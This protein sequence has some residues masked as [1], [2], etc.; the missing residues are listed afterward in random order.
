M[1][2]WVLLILPTQTEYCAVYKIGLGCSTKELMYVIK[3]Y[4]QVLDWLLENG[5][6]LMVD[7]LGGSPLHDA[8]EHGRLHA[9]TLFPVCCYC[10]D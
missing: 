2:G 9:S 4:L 8:A 3:Y 7:N 1:H 10:L 5:A 6:K